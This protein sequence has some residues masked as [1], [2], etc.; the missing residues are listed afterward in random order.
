MNRAILTGSEAI[1]AQKQFTT[2]IAAYHRPNL[3]RAHKAWPNLY[4]TVLNCT[5]LYLTVLYYTHCCILDNT[6]FLYGE[7]G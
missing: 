4:Y 6:S 2:P 5:V 1:Y 7:Y 3:E